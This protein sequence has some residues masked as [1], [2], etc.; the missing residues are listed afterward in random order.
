MVSTLMHIIYGTMVALTLKLNL[1]LFL[2]FT[3]LPDLD[4][5]LDVLN[6]KL[7]YHAYL[8]HN[9]F[10]Y[11]LIIIIG[12]TFFSFKLVFLALALHFFLD[13]F[14]GKK[15]YFFPLSHR[16][17]GYELLK[18]KKDLSRLWLFL[19]YEQNIYFT[20]ISLIIFIIFLLIY[21]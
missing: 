7:K 2:I 17:F 12:S 1:P 3:N 9:F 11:V 8:F 4:G 15:K 21:L 16:R 5:V 18:K 10:F 14:D 20:I 6:N 19:V 13:F